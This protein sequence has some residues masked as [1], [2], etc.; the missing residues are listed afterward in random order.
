MMKKSFSMDI[1]IRELQQ[2]IQGYLQQHWKLF[3]AEGL[4]FIILGSIAIIIPQ[5]F[6][7]GIALFLGWLLLISGIAQS[8]RAV[9]ISS[10][11]GFG[12]W[13]FIGVLQT[14]IGYFLI[15]HPAEGAMTLT[16]MLTVFFALEG[17]IKIYMAFM[18]RPL[19]RWGWVFFS[20]ITALVLAIIVWTGWPG[21][22]L[23]VL[24]L[25]LGINMIFLGW[26]LLSISL[27]HKT[28]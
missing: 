11:P 14:G 5:V 13:L 2:K 6:T 27:H 19:A 12:L 3:V 9:S 28:L 23:W 15:A 1:E 10:M 4:F 16:L 26:S 25:L 20:G 18:M 7:V 24:G 8:I 22:G 17:M 21:T